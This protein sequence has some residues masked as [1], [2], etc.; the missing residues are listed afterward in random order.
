M[1]KTLLGLCLENVFP[2]TF[3]PWFGIN[4]FICLCILCPFPCHQDNECWVTHVGSLDFEDGT[5]SYEEVICSIG[6]EIGITV[7]DEGSLLLTVNGR[8]S[9]PIASSIPVTQPIWAIVDVYGCTKQVTFLGYSGA[10]VQSLQQICAASI[11]RCLSCQDD[12]AKIPIPLSS[13]QLVAKL[14]KFKLGLHKQ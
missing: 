12:L 10:D 4:V 5:K 2:T 8:C 7:N 13:R 9:V 3:L 14:L 1:D 6:N 11:V